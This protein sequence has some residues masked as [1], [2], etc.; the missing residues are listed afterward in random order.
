MEKFA[1]RPTA[2]D[3][4]IQ[5]VPE[6]AKEPDAAKDIRQIKTKMFVCFVVGSFVFNRLIF[7]VDQF[8]AFFIQGKVKFGHK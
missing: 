1:Y 3:V 6:L 4:V 7:E 8:Q 2:P 5:T